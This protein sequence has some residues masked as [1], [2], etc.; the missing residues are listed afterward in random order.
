MAPATSGA[1]FLA[2]CA[3]LV[4]ADGRRTPTFIDGPLL[5]LGLFLVVPDPFIQRQSIYPGGGV[6]HVCIWSMLRDFTK[7]Y[8][9]PKQK[10]QVRYALLPAL[11]EGRNPNAVC[12]R[13]IAHSVGVIHIV[14]SPAATAVPQRTV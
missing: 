10:P 14:E 1:L 7:R 4:L 6:A 3:Y 2:L 9:V 5:L 12:H 13:C 11:K 8:R